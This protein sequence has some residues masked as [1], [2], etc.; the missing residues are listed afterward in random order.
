MLVRRG[1]Q[2]DKRERRRQTKGRELDARE[3]ITVRQQDDEW[4]TQVECG[5][6]R[7]NESSQIGML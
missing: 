4:R 5:V 7:V 2:R 3:E 1:F 6:I